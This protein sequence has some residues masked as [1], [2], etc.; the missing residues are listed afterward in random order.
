MTFKIGQKIKKMYLPYTLVLGI[1][2]FS[3]DGFKNS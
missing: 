1:Y 2:I 3:K